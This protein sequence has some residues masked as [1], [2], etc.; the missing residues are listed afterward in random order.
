LSERLRS[1][2]VSA[3]PAALVIGCAHLPLVCSLNFV[4][5]VGRGVSA[6]VGANVSPGAS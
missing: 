3:Q 5:G 1:S 6:G 2:A 4:E